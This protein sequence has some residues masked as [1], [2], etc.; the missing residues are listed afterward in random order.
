MVLG[1]Q[2]FLLVVY[3]TIQGFRHRGLG[4]RIL[5]SG[6]LILGLGL[7]VCGELG[8]MYYVEVTFPYS[9]LAPGKDG[10]DK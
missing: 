5:G 6:L 7:R 8:N 1:V 2:G 10:Q 4:F 9:I 3:R